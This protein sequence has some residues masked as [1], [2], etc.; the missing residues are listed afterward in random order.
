MNDELKELMEDYDLE[1]GEAEEIQDIADE[2]GVDT[3]NA[4]EIWEA[5]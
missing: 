3:D 2:L 5:M 4:H 1:E